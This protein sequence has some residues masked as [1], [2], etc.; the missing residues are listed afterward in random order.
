[1]ER[2]ALA[3]EARLLAAPVSFELVSTAHAEGIEDRTTMAPLAARRTAEMVA[4]GRRIV[5]V[6]L[7]VAAQAV[8][9][10]GTGQ[11]GRGTATAHAAIRRIIP[12]TDRAGGARPGGERPGDAPPVTDLRAC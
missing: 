2:Q 7:T 10:R 11:L 12:S 1:M 9:L 4:L 5:A 8:E 6:E 3:V